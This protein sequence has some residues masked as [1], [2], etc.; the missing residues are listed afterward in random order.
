MDDVAYS[1]D[2][3]LVYAA[4]LSGGTYRGSVWDV[5]TGELVRDNDVMLHE[6]VAVHPDGETLV[7]VSGDGTDLVVLDSDFSTVDELN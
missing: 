7:T 2:G 1:A 6:Y 4:G 5:R 3:T